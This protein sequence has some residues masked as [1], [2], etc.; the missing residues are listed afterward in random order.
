MPFLFNKLNNMMRI[1]SF[2]KRYF[3]IVIS[4]LISRFFKYPITYLKEVLPFFKQILKPRF[5]YE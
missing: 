1:S 3:V 4:N 5:H 2:K